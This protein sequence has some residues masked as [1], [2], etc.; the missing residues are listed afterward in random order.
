M[1]RVGGE[2]YG[3][4]FRSDTEAL[5]VH[6]RVLSRPGRIGYF[7]QLLAM[8][9]WTSLPWLRSIH[10]PTLVMMGRDDPI[11]PLVHG[12]ILTALI[13]DPRLHVINDGHLFLLSR[14]AEAVGIIA[15]FLSPRA[16]LA[17]IPKHDHQH[18]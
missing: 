16:H 11:V 10:Q 15:G 1:V 4:N 8:S 9:G 18:A 7:Y 6:G 2:L 14:T 13:S 3:G 12:R 17:A 5:R